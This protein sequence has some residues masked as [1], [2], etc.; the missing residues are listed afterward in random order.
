MFNQILW[1]ETFTY[2]ANGNRATKTTPWGTIKYEYDRENRLVKKGNIVYAYDMDGN[3]LSETGGYRSAEYRYNGQNRMA[4]SGVTDH[5]N[6]ATA[7]S[8]YAY[9]A[10]GR[11]TIAQEAGRTAMRTLYDG[12]TFEAIR[13]SETFGYGGFTVRTS[14]GAVL[15]SQSTPGTVE[16][17]RFRQVTEG[18]STWL[19]NSPRQEQR[20]GTVA[21]PEYRY[22]GINATLYAN[23]EAVAMN[24]LNTSTYTGGT[25]YLGKDVMGSVRGISNDYGLLEERYEYDAFGR[26]YKGDLNSGMN[27]GYTGKPYDTATGLYNYG[28]RDYQPEVARFTTVDPIRDGANWFVYVNNDPVNWVDLWGLSASDKQYITV[29][30]TGLE[31]SLFSAVTPKGSIG[32]IKGFFDASFYVNDSKS[33]DFTARYTYTVTEKTGIDFTFAGLSVIAGEGTKTFNSPQTY[34]TITRDFQNA[35]TDSVVAGLTAGVSG[36]ISG[37]TSGGWIYSQSSFGAGAGFEI[38]GSFGTEHTETRLV[39]NF[40][41]Y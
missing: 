11:R 31:I 13:E 6:G 23:G 40:I 35:G 34:E 20:S 18:Y 10:F 37:S 29:R 8:E 3:L 33:P 28:Y 5:T 14:S 39:E 4:Y 24:R 1:R 21:A 19:G 36:S 9:D 27:L 25:V 41:K 15:P 16:E 26:P 30:T 17:G 2:D 32:V 7:V 12:F 38:S 22:V